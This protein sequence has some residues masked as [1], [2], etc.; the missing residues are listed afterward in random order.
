MQQDR[1]EQITAGADTPSSSHDIRVLIAD[2]HAATRT[3]VRRVLEA[4]GLS[5]V[6]EAVTSDEAVAASLEHRP[7]VCLLGVRIPGNGIT[8]AERIAEALPDTKIVML[9]ADDRDE[10]VFRA[11][12]AGADGFLLKSTPAMR[13]SHAIRGV[14]H[15]EA[16]LTR[17][18]TARLIREFRD[19]GRRQR[20]SINISGRDV[21]LTSRE[22]EVLERMRRGDR[23]GEIADR[24]QI[25]DVTVR[26][27]ISTILKKLGVPDRR[28]AV[29][30]FGSET[31]DALSR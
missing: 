3:G 16:A 22:F 17:R 13:L 27:H 10:D 19:A 31:G 26:R 21:D 25:S 11:L 18:L 30:L 2:D 1:P 4:A 24:L 5:V 14:V 23:T 12:R 6:A 15:G 9:S 8:A 20:V 7:S 29:E 28:R